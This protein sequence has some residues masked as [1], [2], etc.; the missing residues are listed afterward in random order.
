MA[1][2]RIA[3]HPESPM[4]KALAFAAALLV[5]TPVFA[6]MADDVNVQIESL[7]G[8]HD[9][10]EIAIRTVQ[11]GVAN[12]E[13][14]KVAGYVPFGEPIMVNGEAV[15]IADE[16][17]L[18]ARFDELFNEKVVNAVSGQ[19]YETLFVNQDGIM[20]GDGELWIGGVCI[21]D[22]CNDFFVNIIA[23]NNQ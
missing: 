18:A 22:A 12:H 2:H 14:E 11:E 4:F 8:S 20:F 13:I 10:F 23:I 19:K 1:D 21:D 6:Q 5:A 17:D 3:Q 15:V 16:A 9:I 7:L